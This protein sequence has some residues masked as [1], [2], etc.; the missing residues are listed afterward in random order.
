MRHGR[1]CRSKNGAT[2]TPPC[3]CGPRS[4]ARSASRRRFGSISPGTSCFMRRHAA[5]P[6]LSSPTA[7]AAFSSISISSCFWSRPA[8]AKK[9]DRALPALC[10]RLLCRRH[11]LAPGPGIDVGVNQLP[12][13]IPTEQ[14]LMEFLSSTYEAAATTG[15]WDR[16][17][18]ECPLGVPGVPRPI[19]RSR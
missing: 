3:T 18:L 11:A 15:N 13:E 10:R 14:T 7:I 1:A 16:T 2:P 8:T 17:A 4:S 12:N 6:P 9:R 19:A 5:L